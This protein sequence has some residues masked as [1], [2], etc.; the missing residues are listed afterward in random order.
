MNQA[1]PFVGARWWKFDFHTHTRA[2]KDTNAWQAAIGAPDELTP[3]K[4]ILKYMAAG[5]DCVAVTDHNSGEWVV[6]VK[7][8]RN[9]SP[10]R[11][12]WRKDDHENRVEEW[13][14]D[15]TGRRNTRLLNRF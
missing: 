3:Q 1:W 9:G 11:L 13:K 8:H 6:H 14:A 15:S 7:I 5:I 10:Y 2:S 12:T 4:W